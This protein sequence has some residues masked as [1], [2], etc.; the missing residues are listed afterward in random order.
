MSDEASVNNEATSESDATAGESR[1]GEPPRAVLYALYAV[2]IVA[3]FAVF[4]IVG[5]YA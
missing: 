2:L 3:L 5:V 4:I 1:E